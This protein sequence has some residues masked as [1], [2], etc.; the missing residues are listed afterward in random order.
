MLGWHH[1]ASCTRTGAM[2]RWVSHSRALQRAPGSGFACT[3]SR[4]QSQIGSGRGWV[5]HFRWVPIGC[6]LH[7]RTQE[8]PTRTEW[9]SKGPGGARN[10]GAKRWWGE[11][12]GRAT[13]SWPSRSE[14]GGHLQLAKCKAREQ[15]FLLQIVLKRG[16]CGGVL[17]S[18]IGYCH[19]SLGLEVRARGR[20]AQPPGMGGRGGPPVRGAS[21]L[22]E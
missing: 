12:V 10:A 21:A 11:E 1:R 4:R 18:H 20:W 13:L 15:P 16:G 3:R 17:S 14:G 8:Q 9:C 19:M 5:A 22:S 6:A 2:G 7:R